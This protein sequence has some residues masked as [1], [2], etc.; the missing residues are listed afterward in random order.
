MKPYPQKNARKLTAI[1]LDKSKGPLA[2]FVAPK[3]V[4][5]RDLGAKFYLLTIQFLYLMDFKVMDI[6]IGKKASHMVKH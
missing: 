4:N 3:S 1:G 5:L 6:I 2:K